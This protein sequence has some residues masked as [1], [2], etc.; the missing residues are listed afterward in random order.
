MSLRD[1]SNSALLAIMAH[2]DICA[3]MCIIVHTVF[4]YIPL[5]D[6][7]GLFVLITQCMNLIFPKRPLKKWTCEETSA[8]VVH[9]YQCHRR[10]PFRDSVIELSRQDLNMM[11][12]TIFAT[13]M[14]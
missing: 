10:I 7:D 12:S 13:K 2:W 6:V 4:Y 14:F 8:I 9:T 5:L 3:L 1:V 11:F